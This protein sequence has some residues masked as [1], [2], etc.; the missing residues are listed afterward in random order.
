MDYEEKLHVVDEE[1]ERLRNAIGYYRM[2]VEKEAAEE[3]KHLEA[4]KDSPVHIHFFR[5]TLPKQTGAIRRASMDLTRALAE[6]RRP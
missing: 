5:G 1:M 2:A 6:L 4:H 3:E